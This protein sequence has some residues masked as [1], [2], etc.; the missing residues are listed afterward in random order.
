MDINSVDTNENISP[1][2]LQALLAEKSAAE[3]AVAQKESELLIA[4]QNLENINKRISSISENKAEEE[5][6]KNI[7]AYTQAQEPLN[8]ENPI[9]SAALESATMPTDKTESILSVGEKRY[10]IISQKISG[11]KE[12][13]KTRI[14][15]VGSKLGN[16]FRK[17]K[18]F[19]YEIPKNISIAVLSTDK[20][21]EAGLTAGS[22]KLDKGIGFVDNMYD[23]AFDKIEGGVVGLGNWIAEKAKATKRFTEEKAVL[24]A[25]VAAYKAER[26]KE[27]LERM[28]DSIFNQF[29]R[30]NNF[31]TEAGN[32]ASAEVNRIKM[33]L[34]DEIIAY[35]MRELD[36]E[37]AKDSMVA[38]NLEEAKQARLNAIKEKAE[39]LVSLREG[40]SKVVVTNNSQVAI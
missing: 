14:S 2:E 29:R 15:S 12:N 1:I 22:N 25:S 40:L 7:E 10:E 26:T 9:P 35:K 18:D 5:S 30:L 24:I 21:I 8:I 27:G 28:Q 11:I 19:G 6:P 16:F 36:K 31:M 20:I 3:Q 37:I 34:K 39:K 33:R 23:K 32:F 38:G 13:A 4:K 17:I